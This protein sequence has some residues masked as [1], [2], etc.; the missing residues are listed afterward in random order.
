MPGGRPASS[1]GRVRVAAATG[2]RRRRTAAPAGA[3]EPPCAQRPQRQR[4]ATRLAYDE[5]FRRPSNDVSQ[6][7]PGTLRLVRRATRYAHGEGQRTKKR[8]KETEERRCSETK[9][10]VAAATANAG[11]ARPSI[12]GAGR[13]FFCNRIALRL[14]HFRR[15]PSFTRETMPPL[16]GCPKVRVRRCRKHRACEYRPAAPHR[17]PLASPGAPRLRRWR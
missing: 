13:N 17:L 10:E 1:P 6:Q 5:S 14:F 16:A 9:N 11:S 15:S 7:A 2:R 12:V 3:G 4:V 8:K